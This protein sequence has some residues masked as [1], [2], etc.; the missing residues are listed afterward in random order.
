M[1]VKKKGDRNHELSDGKII[2][3]LMLYHVFI[4]FT[5]VYDSSPQ[6]IDALVFR[7]DK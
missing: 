4:R 2:T 7:C 5:S 3:I 1:L 6:K